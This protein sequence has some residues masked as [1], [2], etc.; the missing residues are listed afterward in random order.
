MV[1]SQATAQSRPG[2]RP[3]TAQVS[4]AGDPGFGRS[5]LF[6]AVPGRVASIRNRDAGAAET[7]AANDIVGCSTALSAALEAVHV[8]AATNA[9]VLISGETGTGKELFARALHVGSPRRDKPLVTVNCAA[10]PRELI[11]SEL[12]G[13]ERGAFTNASD[14]RIGRFESADGGTLF[15]DEIGE[16]PPEA[17]VKLLRVLQEHSLERVGGNDSISLDVRIIAATN[18]NL[19]KMVDEGSFRADLFYRLNVFP[20]HI[21]PLR[22]RHGDVTLLARHFLRRLAARNGKRASRIAGE[23]LRRLEAYSWPGNVRELENVIER[24]IIMASA[25]APEIRLAGTLTASV[26]GSDGRASE[27]A[28]SSS[29][30]DVVRRHIARVLCQCGGT[31]EGAGGAA[32]MLGLKPSTLRYRIKQLQLARTPPQPFATRLLASGE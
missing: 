24:M 28:C 4:G 18:R 17:Q 27:S 22:E 25:D 9:T 21:P 13:H 1:N 6:Q 20:V 16:L 29:L 32:A 11:E 23:T 7:T 19:P 10:L 15:L 30:D 12:F 2:R 5:K 26:P 14:R 8:V 3:L 31:I